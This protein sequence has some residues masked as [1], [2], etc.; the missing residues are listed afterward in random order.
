LSQYQNGPQSGWALL[1]AVR[2]ANGNPAE[3][4]KVRAGQNVFIPELA[5]RGQTLAGLG[6]SAVAV[7]GVNQFYI[8]QTEYIEDKTSATLR[9]TL[10]N[11]FDRAGDQI[12]RLSAAVDAMNRSRKVT[13]I[14]QAPGA[15]LSGQGAASAVA[16]AA[17]QAI[18]NAIQFVPRLSTVPT[19]GQIAVTTLSNTNTNGTPTIFNISADGAVVQVLSSAAGPCLYVFSYKINV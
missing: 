3:L 15:P 19:S 12:A 13:S 6:G 2:D 10:D 11:F 16:T 9:L 5:V 14:L 7:P 1:G 4:W 8:M 18:A 17:G